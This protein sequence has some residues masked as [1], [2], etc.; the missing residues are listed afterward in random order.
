[1]TINLI[2]LL[3]G[4]LIFFLIAYGARLVIRHLAAP[5]P[6]ETIVMLVLL[7]LFIV[8]LVGEL[9][10]SGPVIRIGEIG[11]SGDAE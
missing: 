4:P 7:V 2:H 3:L 1:M 8:W 5:P 10:L 6:V 11:L 9:G